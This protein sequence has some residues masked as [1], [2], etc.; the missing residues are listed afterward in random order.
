MPN[1]SEGRRAAV[2][3]EDGGGEDGDLPV[4]HVDDRKFSWDD[5]GRML[6]AYAG[7]GMRIVFVPDDELERS[8]KTV[9]G[10][11]DR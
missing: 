6:L 8:P 2:P 1:G 4:I 7:W 5:F 3:F 10:E 9:V 11:P